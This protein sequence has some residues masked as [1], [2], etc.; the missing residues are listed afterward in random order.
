M[1]V[2]LTFLSLL[3]PA[4]GFFYK[5]DK[6]AEAKRKG[7]DSMIRKTYDA[8]FLF[9]PDASNGGNIM[10]MVNT[11][12]ITV[13]FP[14][15][16]D[17]KKKLDFQTPHFSRDAT[18]QIKGWRGVGVLGLFDKGKTHILNRIFCMELPHG[19]TQTTQ[20]ISIVFDYSK[21]D[22][23]DFIRQDPW[24][25]IDSAGFQATVDFSSMSSQLTKDGR[26]AMEATL[27]AQQQVYEQFIFDLV[28]YT[29]HLALF[30]VNDLTWIEQQLIQRV[31]E[32]QDNMLQEAEEASKRSPK[33]RKTKSAEK[34][35]SSKYN[36]M[37]IHNMK[38]VQKSGL[39]RSCSISS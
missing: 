15:P 20:G 5:A 38:T 32:K 14:Q 35:T 26:K 31:A 17:L 23:S 30:I 1:R 28:A 36:V 8:R 10:R 34:Q 22:E 25:V 2:S 24:L 21:S 4:V 16:Q 7:K 33:D 13:D 11:K 12:S 3:P 37:V 18:G 6:C 27:I 39:W 19:N 29:A 9:G